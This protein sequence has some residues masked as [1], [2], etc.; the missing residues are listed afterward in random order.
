MPLL[1]KPEKNIS[2]KKKKFPNGPDNIGNTMRYLLNQKGGMAQPYG[3]SY[4]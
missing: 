1:E 4:S 3:I 2:L